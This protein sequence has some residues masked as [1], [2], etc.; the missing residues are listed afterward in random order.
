MFVGDAGRVK[1]DKRLPGG[2]VA[3]FGVDGHSNEFCVI[4]G[5]GSGGGN[6]FS[7]DFGGT[8]VDGWFSTFSSSN[9]QNITLLPIL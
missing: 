2:A 4:G 9:P 1:S 8:G 7:L 6:G 5:G 3:L